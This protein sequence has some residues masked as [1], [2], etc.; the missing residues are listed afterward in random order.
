MDINTIEYKNKLL[1]I[2]QFLPQ[3]S[4]QNTSNY[5]FNFFGF[6]Q[7]SL[8]NEFTNYS[9]DK[10]NQIFKS[11]LNIIEESEEEIDFNKLYFINNSKSNKENETNN[12]INDLSKEFSNYIAN[13]NIKNKIFK[14]ES[15]KSTNIIKELINKKRKRGRKRNLNICKKGLEIHSAF[16][17]DN[18]LKKIRVHFL[19][20]CISFI[21]DL[22]RYISQYL[23]NVTYNFLKLDNE[24]KTNV[25][26]KTKDSLKNKTLGEIITNKI[27]D[28]YKRYDKKTN[29]KIYEKLINHELLNEIFSINYKQ[30]FKIYYNSKKIINLNDYELNE[31]I[32]N[33]YE[34]NKEILL[35]SKVKL[36][37]DLLENNTT[38]KDLL[39]ENNNL[40]AQK[41]T[42]SLRT[43]AIN[44]YLSN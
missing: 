24:L 6:V 30:L 20:F 16:S 36:F 25:N 39:K 29:I 11:G 34:L 33:K 38:Y 2:N 17:E 40:L 41:Y 7:D 44:N 15:T 21:N 12:K 8:F 10:L 43:C 18:L 26:K 19:N 9:L 22:Y 13:K 37:N 27:N 14:I 31:E 28:K 32:L 1:K 3:L 5:Y 42:N 4:I 23:E 35:S